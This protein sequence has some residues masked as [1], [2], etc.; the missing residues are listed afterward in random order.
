MF[1]LTI[2]I[3]IAIATKNSHFMLEILTLLKDSSHQQ[4]F[5]DHAGDAF[6][7]QVARRSTSA[8]DWI[9]ANSHNQLQVDLIS[10]LPPFPNNLLPPSGHQQQRS[11]RFYQSGTTVRPVSHPR[12][13]LLELKSLSSQGCQRKEAFLLPVAAG[14][15]RVMP[16]SAPA[17]PPPPPSAALV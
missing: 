4:Y 2:T 3:T 5:R 11:E 16:S 15:T 13:F 14:G 10:V 7:H 6:E 17:A 12:A 9:D 1:G 8:R